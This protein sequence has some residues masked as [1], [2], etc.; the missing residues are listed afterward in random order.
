MKRCVNCGCINDDDREYCRNCESGEFEAMT[1]G[2]G[3][4]FP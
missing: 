4:T 2:R 3:E 1:S